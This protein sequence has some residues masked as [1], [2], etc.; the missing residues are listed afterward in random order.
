LFLAAAVLALP[1]LLRLARSRG[2]LSTAARRAAWVA[3][4]ASALWIL[5]GIPHLLAR[6]D[7]SA[8][9]AGQ[10][11]PFLTGHLIGAVIVYPLVGFSIASLAVLS[12]RSLVHPIIGLVGAMGPPRSA[13]HWTH[14]PYP[15]API[16]VQFRMAIRPGSAAAIR[17][18]MAVDHENPA[19]ASLV[20]WPVRAGFMPRGSLGC[21]CSGPMASRSAGFATWLPRCASDRGRRGCSG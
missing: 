4:G 5:E 21:R 16:A 12:G 18:R 7:E 6:F 3:A 17:R 1:G 14:Q 19:N 15:P 13:S 10:P 11:T 8:V 9:L 2:A 20:L